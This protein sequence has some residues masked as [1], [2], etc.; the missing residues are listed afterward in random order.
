MT[1][2]NLSVFIDLYHIKFVSIIFLIEIYYL[3][4]IHTMLMTLKFLYY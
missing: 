4:T 1:G 3:I 2:F